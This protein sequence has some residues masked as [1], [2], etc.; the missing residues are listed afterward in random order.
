MEHQKILNLL[1]EPSNSRKW[2]I[3]NDQSN[4]NYDVGNAITYYTKVSKSNTCDYSNAC[5]LVRGNITITVHLVT[6]VAFKNCAPFTKCITKI[7][8]TAIDDAADLDLVMQC[9][10]IYC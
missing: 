9:R 3:F 7:D 6:Q 2:N 1:N 5:T 10:S 8:G 4:A